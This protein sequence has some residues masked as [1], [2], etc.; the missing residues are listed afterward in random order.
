MSLFEE[1]PAD[2]QAPTEDKKVEDAPQ[3]DFI[4]E[5][6]K[7]K[8]PE[9][10]LQSI[11]HKEQFI[12]Q[13]KRENEELR[14]KLTESSKIDDV[15]TR[16]QQPNEQPTEAKPPTNQVDLEALIEQHISQREKKLTSGQN[17][18]T[19]VGKLN[20]LY[21]D[22]AEQV[23]NDKA[24]EL[25]IPVEWLNET[26]KQSPTAI[27]E[28]FGINK[29]AKPAQSKPTSSVNS[30]ALGAIPQTTE[31][32]NIMYGSTTADIVD[33]WRSYSAKQ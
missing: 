8:S 32:K 7:Y 33:A 14:Q 2:Q 20:E 11:P 27:F 23:Y 3:F 1:K 28:L 24:K 21:G 10:A 9:D 6:K 19:V 18:A 22:K 15:L 16:L 5:G 4:G 17:A 30:S 31:R 29:A 26:A 25:G 13:L 12:E